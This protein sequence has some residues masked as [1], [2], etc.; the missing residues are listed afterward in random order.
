MTHT[1]FSAV[2]ALA[3]LLAAGLVF[4]PSASAAVDAFLKIDGVQ[5]ESLDAKHPGWIEV[6]S[7]QL[8]Q[9]RDS[10]RV[11][12]AKTRVG[13]GKV[14]VHDINITKSTDKASP[15]LMKFC[16]TGKHIPSATL[17]VRKAGGT[18][19][20]YLVIT[21]KDVF[22]SS[23][24]TSGARGGGGAAGETFVLNAADATIE[25]SGQPTP[26]AGAKNLQ[27]APGALRS[28]SL[29]PRITGA[30]AAAP[31]VGTGVTLTI[32]STGPCSNALVDWGDSP[33]GGEGHA[34]TGAS[35]T[36]P[37]HVY[38]TAGAKTIKVGGRDASYWKSS[39]K[40]SPSRAGDC[41]GEAPLVSV[42][43]R[44]GAVAAPIVR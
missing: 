7:F 18:Q 34:L 23:Y 40:M 29:V 22:L 14:S 9:L 8:V 10:A 12:G 39:P 30:S 25:Y 28:V 21:L 33:L 1:R 2:S 3:L 27:L 41:T 15:A 42:T 37:T 32:T 19:Q 11:G 38:A 44:S 43:L 36:L 35:T 26:A 6:S 17:S 24:Q 5:G 13:A 20:D 31:F 4:A 16:A